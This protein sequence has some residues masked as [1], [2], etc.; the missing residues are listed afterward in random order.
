MEN[1]LVVAGIQDGMEGCGFNRV[2]RGRLVV[3]EIFYIWLVVA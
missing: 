1:R 3:M 2:A